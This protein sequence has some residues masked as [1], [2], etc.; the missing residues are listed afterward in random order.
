MDEVSL[1]QPT[2]HGSEVGGDMS[3]ENVKGMGLGGGGCEKWKGGGGG[4]L[5]GMDNSG[6][7]GVEGEGGV[8]GV[9]E[10]E[11]D[12]VGVEGEGDV[13]V[14]EGEGDVVDRMVEECAL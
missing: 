7:V 2:A 13:V 14:V 6:V 9:V 5:V 3:D 1:L 8:V 10:G 4:P 12:V 11:G